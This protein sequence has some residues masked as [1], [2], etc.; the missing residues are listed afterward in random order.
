M[1][2][3]D[4]YFEPEVRDGFYISSEMKRC[5]A[6]TLEVLNNIDKVC[7][8]Y[9]IKYYADYGTM[10]GAVRHKGFIP[11][12]DDLDIA[13][14]RDDYLRFLKVAQDEL[15]E[16]YLVLSIFTNQ[17]YDNF[18]SR[19]VNHNFMSMEERFLKE[20]HDFPYATGVD[21]F[22]LDYFVKNDEENEI[23]KK[24]ILMANDL[25]Q[26][27]DE[28]MFYSDVDDIIR[29][30]MESLAA[31][32]GIEIS[33]NKPLRQQSLIIMDRLMSIYGKEESDK[34]VSMHFWVENGSHVYDRKLFDEIVMMPFEYTS[35]PMPIG[36]NAILTLDYG[37]NYMT[38]VKNSGM[39]DYPLY[40]PQ[41]E[42]MFDT[43]GRYYYES[44]QYSEAVIH[45]ALGHIH[46]GKK[47]IV[48]LPFKASAWYTMEDEWRQCIDDPNNDVYV[49][50]IPYYYKGSMRYNQSLQYD[51]DKFPEYVSVI[52][53]DQ[54]DF[55]SRRPDRIYIQCP[56]D[57]YD[58]GICVHPR[59]YSSQMR[60]VTSELIY[61]PYFYVDD[62]GEHEDRAAYHAKS[63]INVPGV[64]N[65]DKVIVQSETIRDRYLD[66]IKEFIGIEDIRDWEERITVRKEQVHSSEE[67]LVIYEDEV[68][69]SW[70]KY[71]LDDNGEGKKTILYHTCVS[72]I[73]SYG[74]AYFKKLRN[75]ID[76]FKSNRDNIALIWYAHHETNRILEGRYPELWSEYIEIVNDYLEDEVGIYEDKEDYWKA[77]AISDAYYGDRDAIMN[78]F[79]RMKKP[80]MIQAIE[81]I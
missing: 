69:E 21:V 12:D 75:V 61:I 3:P 9:G 23:L 14:K 38:P 35:I 50:P 58:M 51:G 44:Y 29:K 76:T 31:V 8:K 57:E 56:Y 22:P 34:L 41:K 62:F 59:F 80:V 48:F 17:K 81:L 79:R 2:I 16:G 74:K 33:H 70:W 4:S 65:A 68:P 49:I 71:L 26:C 67:N 20:G 60:K 77:A 63:Y 7:K 24:L 78:D 45:S 36:Y 66:A 54:Y 40:L 19:V 52:G 11:W 1:N 47:E 10:L 73:V 37:P 39:H 53:F 5:W 13:M 42:L 27:L 72:D 6:S 28:A 55:D 43:L 25:N 64:Y 18:L 32:C 30:K 46:N 15:P